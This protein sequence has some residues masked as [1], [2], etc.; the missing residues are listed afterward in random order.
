MGCLASDYRLGLGVGPAKGVKT[1]LQTRDIDHV[2]PQKLTSAFSLSLHWL[3]QQPIFSPFTVSGF[4]SGQ[5]HHL[6][7]SE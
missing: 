5:N 1:A 3:S 2:N 6:Q 7:K 4:F